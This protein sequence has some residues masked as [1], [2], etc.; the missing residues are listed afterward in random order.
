[1]AFN[2][3]ISP[4]HP[5]SAPAGALPERVML[6]HAP[7]QTSSQPTEGINAAT[8]LIVD[9]HPVV[10]DGI[11]FA[12]QYC[13]DI[14]IVGEA[15]SGEEALRLVPIL[16]PSV[17]LMDLLMPGM[18]GITTIRALHRQAPETR[19]LVLTTV[20]R[21]DAVRDA[22]HAGAVGYYLKGAFTGDLVQA[23]RSPVQGQPSLD[24]GAALLLAQLAPR[25]CVPSKPL[26]QR[27]REVLYLL[28]QGLS[29]AKIAEALVVTEP[30]VKH[31][32]RSIRRKLQATSR[33]HVVSLALT[34]Q[35][36]ANWPDTCS[37][38]SLEG[39]GLAGNGGETWAP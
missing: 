18:G 27:E 8:V 39:K 13:S 26:T 25:P 37:P 3:S 22:L 32:V 33:T 1:M 14:H 31:H 7:K 2:R 24:T 35:V 38:P 6:A 28:A 15:G 19:I 23:I 21:G 20:E 34:H 5:P 17:V 9:D 30:T 36:L 16:R 29:N 12:L 11:R 4:I 10:R